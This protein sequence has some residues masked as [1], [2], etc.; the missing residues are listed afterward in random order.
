M[1]LYV[2]R[3]GPPVIGLI[4]AMVGG[5]LLTDLIVMS[6]FQILLRYVFI[7]LP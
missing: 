6:I 4:A 5:I 3:A 1:N 2:G 7:T